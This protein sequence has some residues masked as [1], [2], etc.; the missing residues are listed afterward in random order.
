MPI[1]DYGLV[2]N[3]TEKAVFTCAY[4]SAENEV[5]DSEGEFRYELYPDQ[6]APVMTKLDQEWFLGFPQRFEIK[7]KDRVLS[8]KVTPEATLKATQDKGEEVLRRGRPKGATSEG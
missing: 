4:E 1:N 6:P 5:K 7:V 2:T 3:L 8:R